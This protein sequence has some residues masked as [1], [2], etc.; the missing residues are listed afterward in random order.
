MI[1]TNL[2]YPMIILSTKYHKH[3][4]RLVT[5]DENSIQINQNMNSAQEISFTVHKEFD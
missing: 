2:E 5:V 1:Y 4:G 3:L